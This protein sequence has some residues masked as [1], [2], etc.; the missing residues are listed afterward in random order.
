MSKPEEYGP[1]GIGHGETKGAVML[2]RGL[3]PGEIA[4]RRDQHRNG[5]LIMIVAS[6]AAPVPTIARGTA[7]NSLMRSR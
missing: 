5:L 1:A 2:L 3:G 7:V 6:R 4:R